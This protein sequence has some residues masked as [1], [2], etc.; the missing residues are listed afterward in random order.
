MSCWPA[1]PEAHLHRALRSISL[2]AAYCCVPIQMSPAPE[3]VETT[4]AFHVSVCCGRRP[5]DGQPLIIKQRTER[6]AAGNLWRCHEN[7]QWLTR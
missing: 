6:E 3:A 7:S 5:P 4:K 2:A 1:E